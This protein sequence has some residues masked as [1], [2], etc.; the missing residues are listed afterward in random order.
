MLKRLGELAQLVVDRPDI[1]FDARKCI[2]VADLA[3]GQSGALAFSGSALQIAFL[4]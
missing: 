2:S 4:G 1:Y 3:H